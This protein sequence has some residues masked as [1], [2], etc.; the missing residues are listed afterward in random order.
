MQEQC[1]IDSQD[2]SDDLVEQLMLENQNLRNL[3]QIGEMPSEQL[4]KDLRSEEVAMGLIVDDTA[5]NPINEPQ[6]APLS[7]L[8][9]EASKQI[10][11]RKKKKEDELN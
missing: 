10:K 6:F 7:S 3:L 5:S 1:K 2:L 4:E 11:E 9:L 8:I